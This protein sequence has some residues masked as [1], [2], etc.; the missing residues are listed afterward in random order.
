[1]TQDRHDMNIPGSSNSVYKMYVPF[2]PENIYSTKGKHF[3]YL[4]DPGMLLYVRMIGIHNYIH[5]LISLLT[6]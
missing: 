6:Y 1:M 2:P 3:T 5:A 4:D